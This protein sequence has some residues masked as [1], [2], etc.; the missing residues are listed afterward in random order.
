MN[1]NKI[2]IFYH[3]D[4]NDGVF[5]GAIMKH[6]LS[7]TYKT[8][9]I[10]AI[11]LNHEDR[12]NI[13]SDL[14]NNVFNKYCSI[15]IVDIS[16]HTEKMIECYNHYKTSMIWIDHHKPIIESLKDYEDLIL[17]IRMT[18]HS[19]MYHCWNY[20]F[21]NTVVPEFI[22]ILSA[23]DSWTYEEAGYDFE[24]VNTINIGTTHE[25]NLEF[26][27]VY[28]IIE[29]LSDSYYNNVVINTNF[30]SGQIIQKEKQQR[31][32]RLIELHSD[33]NWVIAGRKTVAVFINE[34]STSQIFKTLQN[35]E[36]KTGVVFKIDGTDRVVVSVYNINNEDTFH[37]GEFCSKYH[38]GGHTGAGGFS[39]SMDEFMK[40]MITKNIE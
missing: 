40:L 14:V 35:T 23:Y 37:Q 36:Y 34:Q 2:G 32:N 8:Y 13:E 16:F 22:K 38:G 6:F 1:N 24:Y 12:D 18:N 27:K 25:H 4:D 15:A 17:G 31:W 26:D 7:N 28:E 21:P 9:E 29:K 10:E 5:S 33:K 39:V 30:Q 11:G 20:C 3:K 19:A